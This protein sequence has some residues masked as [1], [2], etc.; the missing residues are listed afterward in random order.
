MSDQKKNLENLIRGDKQLPKVLYHY[1]S[2]DAFVSI[3]GHEYGVRFMCTNYRF[4]NDDAEF[5][6]GY[7]MA[8]K[9]MKAH[10]VESE[11]F[12]RVREKMKLTDDLESWLSTP[13]I[14]SLSDN[15]DSAA[16]W[17]SYTD[18]SQ[19]GFAIGVD[20]KRL[21][22]CVHKSD[23]NI[24]AG[25][26]SSQT[27]CDHFI[28]EPIG[29]MFIAPCIYYDNK[30]EKPPET[31]ERALEHIFSEDECF[32][33]L[34]KDE[35]D[36][37]AVHCLRQVLRVSALLKR[38]DF[39]FENEWRV[40]FVPMMAGR[41]LFSGI[42]LIGGKARVSLRQTLDKYHK[43]EI[44]REVIVAPHGSTAKNEMLANLV[45]LTNHGKYVVTTSR[46]SYN[47][48]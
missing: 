33:R 48:R 22:S 7:Q 10:G 28:P 39:Q 44:I 20:S 47:G 3:V 1:T 18:R 15:N 37:Y 14:L 43:R 5:V 27:D 35:P 13:W 21:E 46:S 34:R 32:A 38:E 23:K 26:L 30:A 4:L 17:M 45:K 2:P 40:V 42:R 29:G 8:L 19:G 9:W 41:K 24:K 11:A 16:H 31:F 6:D 12:D 25:C 36:L